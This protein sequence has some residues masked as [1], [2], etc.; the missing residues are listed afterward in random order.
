MPCDTRLKPRQTPV[1]RKAEIAKAVAALERLLT[2]GKTRVVVGR[3]GAIA[4]QGWDPNERDG[5]SDVCAYRALTAANSMALRA[6]VVRAEGLAGV[7]VDAKV[8]ASG[9]HSHTGGLTWDKGH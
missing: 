8:V 4:F 2:A 5:V 9:V 1:Q 7:K 6:A 3:N